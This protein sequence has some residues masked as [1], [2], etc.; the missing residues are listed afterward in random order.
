MS[1]SSNNKVK[2]QYSHHIAATLTNLK[3]SLSCNYLIGIMPVLINLYNYTV[4]DM[5]NLIYFKLN[6]CDLIKVAVTK[7]KL[8]WFIKTCKCTPN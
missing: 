7:A 5:F 1:V 3:I 6:K 8:K 4:Y 2:Y